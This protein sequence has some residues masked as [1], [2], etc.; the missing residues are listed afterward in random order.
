MAETPWPD[1]PVAAELHWLADDPEGYLHFVDP[2]GDRAVVPVTREV[3]HADT[4]RGPVWHIDTPDGTEPG[5]V[6]TVSPSIHY[7]GHFHSPKPVQFR[8]VADVEVLTIAVGDI[9]YAIR[10]PGG[11]I[12][13]KL[14]NGEPYERK[15]LAD[16]A[17]R[18]LHGVAFDVGA[19][20]GN[21]SLYLAAVCGLTVY[22]FEPHPVSYEALVENVRLNPDLRIFPVCVAAGDREGRGRFSGRMRLKLDRGDVP[23]RSLDDVVP[24]GVTVAVVKVDVEGMEPEALAG[25]S[26]HLARCRPVVYAE[27]H[28]RTSARRTAEV[29]A[30]LGY[31]ST[32]VIRMGSPMTVWEAR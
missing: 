23:V 28:T 10:N 25:M 20:V 21:H 15:L 16:I 6:V 19:H 4:A 11:R 3:H 12:G 27:T 31:A 22:A 30:P 24:P 14:V 7:R 32:G 18:D 29:L 13:S 2:N 5:S 17:A 26:G 8:L 1:G 9:S